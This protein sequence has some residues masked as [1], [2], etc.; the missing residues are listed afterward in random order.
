MCVSPTI[1]CS[2]LEKK[3]YLLTLFST[4]LGMLFS[5]TLVKERK[6]FGTVAIL[7]CVGFFDVSYKLVSNAI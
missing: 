4:V 5:Q 2:F 3:R 1:G 7:S 6:H